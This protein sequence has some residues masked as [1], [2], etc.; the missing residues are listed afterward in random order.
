MLF[1][2]DSDAVAPMDIPKHLATHVIPAS[3][4]TG[5]FLKDTG[6][7]IMLEKPIEWSKILAQFILNLQMYQL[8]AGIKINYFRKVIYIVF[9]A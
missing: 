2:G 7:F 6:H 4:L 3:R 1:W 9:V 8:N 5:K